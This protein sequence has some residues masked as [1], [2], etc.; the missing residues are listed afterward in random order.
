M[1][2]GEKVLLA[3]FSVGM[4]WGGRKRLQRGGKEFFIENSTAKSLLL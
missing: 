2:G 3:R 4:T 1:S